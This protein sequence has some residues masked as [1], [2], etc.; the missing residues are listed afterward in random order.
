MKKF[1]FVIPIIFSCLCFSCKDRSPIQ[2]AVD[3]Y[4]AGIISEDSIISFVSD[5]INV[6]ETFEWATRNQSKNNI[7]DWFLGRAYKLGLG[8]D[9]DPIKSKAYYISACK[10]GNGNAMSGLA[11]L[12]A[13]YPGQ[14]NLDSAYY[15]FNEAIQH[16]QADSYFF[17]SQVDIQ[18][19][20]Q[21]G[22]PIDTAKIIEYWE[23]GVKANSPL[24]ISA[25]A[26][27][28]YSGDGVVEPNKT[29]AFNMLALLP[30]DKLNDVSSYLLGE[31][32]ELGEGTNQNFN[33]ALSFYKQSAAK[34]NTDAICKLG[35][36]YQL[37]QGVERN[38]SLAFIQYNKAANAGNPWGQRCVAICYYSGIGTERNVSTANVWYKTAAKGGD[39]EA[40]KYC[41]C[42]KID[43]K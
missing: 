32:Y 18:R 24:C 12:Y 16:G 6:K 1:I 39:I 11:Q 15:W 13:S 9:R 35:N 19:N 36:F 17:V 40:I 38:D 20:I 28:Y 8:V 42:N 25:L 37:G 26:A 31:M 27:L 10:A 4:R 34:G 5:S 2:K 41:D 22:L 3:D 7:A 23:Y 33:A 14:E 30:Q 21:K 29:K 43:Y